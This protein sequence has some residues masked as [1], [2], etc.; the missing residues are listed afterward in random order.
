MTPKEA[1][2]EAIAKSDGLA[3][4][5]ILS[6]NPKLAE[7]NEEGSPLLSAM[8]QGRS[9]LAKIILDAKPSL[10]IF[11]AA[12]TGNT[13]VLQELLQQQP[14]LAQEFATD[15]F[16]ALQLAAFFGHAEAMKVLLVAGANPSSFSKGYLKT[17]PLLAAL[18]SPKPNNAQMLIE[19]GAD[20]N[21]RGDSG[22]TPLHS[23]ATVGAVQML[24]LLLQHGANA[25]VTNDNGE[26]ALMLAQKHNQ[27][28]AVAVLSDL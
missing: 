8:Y 6:E 19:A 27:E 12:A 25:Q 13:Q 10:N 5:K 28:A 1:L 9:E 7:A 11:E 16:T 26:T 24:K 4:L 18:A 22:F 3:L 14:M 2:V 17:S 15:G 23:A 20:L 21:V